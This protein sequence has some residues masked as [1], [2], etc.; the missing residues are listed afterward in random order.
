MKIETFA[1]ERW[2]TAWETKTPYDIAESGIF[3][4]E[5]GTCSTSSRRNEREESS[6]RL[7]DSAWATARRRERRLRAAIAATY[8][9]T[10]PDE[11]WS[12][13]GAIEANFLLF[14]VLLEPGDHVVAVHPGLSAALQRSP[15]HRLR[16]RLWRCAPRTA[17]ATTWTS[18]TPAHAAHTTHRHQHAAQP[19]GSDALRRGLRRIYDLADGRRPGAL[20]RGLPLAGVPGGEPFAPPIRDLG[21][22][23]ISVGTFSKPF[24]LPGLRIGWIA[25][26][27]DLVA[28]CWAMRDYVSLSPGK[29]ERRAGGPRFRLTGSRSSTARR[30]SLREPRAAR[31]WFAETPAVVS[32]TPPRVDSSR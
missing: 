10:C 13:T 30:R 26:P 2:M 7:L 9:D 4:H 1:L 25:A 22:V 24:G 27:E 32:W 17:S 21:G 28:K 15:G 31:A 6:N 5:C 12:T 16:R 18:S 14:N 23:G 19:H 29:V 20:R 11:F 3:P 8:S